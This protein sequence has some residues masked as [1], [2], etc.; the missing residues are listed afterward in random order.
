MRS[1]TLIFLTLFATSGF[2]QRLQEWVDYNHDS[3]LLVS[4]PYWHNE[5]EMNGQL[6]SSAKI[7]G[8]VIVVSHMP[9]G[10][11][12][13]Y[14]IRDTADLRRSYYIFRDEIIKTQHGKLLRSRLIEKDRLTWIHF[15]GRGTVGGI[16]QIIHHMAVFVNDGMYTLA[17]FEMGP[18]SPDKDEAREKIFKSATIA[19]WIPKKQI[20]SK[21]YAAPFPFEKLFP[22]RAILATGIA[23]LIAGAFLLIRKNNRMKLRADSTQIGEE[24]KSS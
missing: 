15:V 18:S 5:R 14:N 4:M 19:P 24:K 1:G 8:A 17:F 23:V 12:T 9:D 22:R 16:D 7:D 13:Q 20:S 11:S 3:T 6:G 2:S 21:L 10:P